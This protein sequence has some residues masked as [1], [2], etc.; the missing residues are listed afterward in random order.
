LSI[1]PQL[2]SEDLTSML[3]V[4]ENLLEQA[5]Y[6]KDSPAIK[7]R[8]LSILSNLENVLRKKIDERLIVKPTGQIISEIVQVLT[9][10]FEALATIRYFVRQN[11]WE[12][13]YACLDRIETEKGEYAPGLRTAIL[14]AEAALMLAAQGFKETA[15]AT[16]ATPIHVPKDLQFGVP[17]V[18]I[19]LYNLLVRERRIEKEDARRRILPPEHTPEQESE[20]EYAWSLLQSKGYAELEVD[21]RGRQ[22]LVYIGGE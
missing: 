5:I 9:P 16:S 17:A 8:I 2:A 1:S 21:K 7:R 11:S 4:L 18:I 3:D 20:F 15:S 10:T 22:H 19:P 6:G 13:A 12:Q 14:R